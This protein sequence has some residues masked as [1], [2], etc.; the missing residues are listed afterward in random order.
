MLDKRIYLPIIFIIFTLALYFV[1]YKNN[2]EYYDNAESNP[3]SEQTTESTSTV[4]VGRQRY[5]I[6]KFSGDSLITDVGI[7]PEGEQDFVDVSTAIDTAFDIPVDHRQETVD[8]FRKN[9][10]YIYTANNNVYDGVPEQIGD[11]TI[12]PEYKKGM[13]LQP[14][15]VTQTNTGTAVCP[16]TKTTEYIKGNVD[17]ASNTFTSSGTMTMTGT[18]T[19]TKTQTGTAIGQAID[20][21]L[22]PV[23]QK[24]HD[25]VMNNIKQID[26]NVPSYNPCWA[27]DSIVN[28]AVDDGYCEGNKMQIANKYRQICNKYYRRDKATDCTDIIKS[29]NDYV[30]KATNINKML[31]MNTNNL[32]SRLTNMRKAN[33]LIVRS[34]HYLEAVRV[35]RLLIRQNNILNNKAMNPL[36]S[37]YNKLINQH[38]RARKSTRCTHI[39]LATNELVNFYYRKFE[40]DMKQ[41]SRVKNEVVNIDDVLGTE[42][43]EILKLVSNNVKQL[44]M[45]YENYHALMKNYV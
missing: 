30:M 21:D 28:K 17:S 3:E 36:L 31:D 13:V 5:V 9:R 24:C 41:I 45:F 8:N 32:G 22:V 6:P 37:M 27:V 35:V 42:I 20:E 33:P 34:T 1:F 4:N 26:V 7:E 11:G 23:S 19:C 25:E 44:N 39:I 14:T 40:Q 15:I 10:P 18:G 38:N 16:T 29:S 2:T 43:D 12:N